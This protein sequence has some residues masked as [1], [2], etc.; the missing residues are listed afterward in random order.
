MCVDKLISKEKILC[1]TT[2]TSGEVVFS[3]VGF[4]SQPIEFVAVLFKTNGIFTFE[5]DGQTL[6]RQGNGLP[7]FCV[8][9]NLSL[10]SP[11][12][13]TLSFTSSQP[14]SIY[15]LNLASICLCNVDEC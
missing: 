1:A 2:G 7:E 3:G 9:K 4:M 13:Y 12:I 14:L 15:E 5:L 11:N 8:L 6:T 10:I